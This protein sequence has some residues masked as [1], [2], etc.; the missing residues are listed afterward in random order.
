MKFDPSRLWKIDGPRT[1]VVLDGEFRYDAAA[2]ARYQAAERFVPSDPISQSAREARNDPRVTPRWPCHQ[3]VTLSW[4]VMIDGE[5]GLRPIRLETRGLPEDDE[6]S[7]LTAFFA[8]MA[9]LG[10]QIELVT[11]GGFSSDLPQILLAAM[12]HGLRLPPALAGLRSPWRRDA[13]K[14]S[15]LMS[16]VAGGANPPHLAEVAARLGIPVKLTCRP[17]LVSRLMAQGKWS[18]VRAVCEGDVWTTA[19]ILMLW[20]QLGGDGQSAF[21]M[22]HRL[23]SFIAATCSHRPYAADWAKFGEDAARAAFAHEAGKMAAIAPH[24]SD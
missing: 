2:H 15:D 18:S 12:T 22:K 13:S 17:D 1:V 11:W 6:C 5:D 4:L 16:E 9:Q 8:D 10:Q 3:L 7:V 23:A 24:L 14:H 21:E 19:M 20:R